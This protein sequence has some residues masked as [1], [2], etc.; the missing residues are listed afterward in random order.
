[1]RSALVGGVAALVAAACGNTNGGGFGDH[2]GADAAAG[3]D[4]GHV[5]GDDGGNFGEGGPTQ[6]GGLV[7]DPKTCAD[8]EKFRSY[9]GCDY[10]P[11]A[12]PNY[13]WSIFD[14][15]VVVA[16]TGQQAANVTVTGPNAVNKSTTVQPNELAKIYLP[17][18]AGLKGQ[19]F[20]NQTAFTD[21][22]FTTIK[23]QG[24]YH[25]VSTVPVTVYQFSALEY[26]AAGGPQGKNWSSCPGTQSGGLGQCFSYSNDASLLLPS[27]AMTPNY[28]LMSPAPIWTSTYVGVTAVQDGTHVAVTLSPKASTP[29]GGGIPAGQ[30]NDVLH[31]TLD[32]GDVAEIAS[33]PGGSDLGGSLVQA[34]KAIEVIA[35]SPCDYTPSGND[36]CCDHLEQS[37]LPAETLGQHYVVTVPTSPGGS[38]VGHLVRVYGNQNGTHLTYAPSKPAGCPDT[39]DAG[40]VADCG[41]QADKLI[42]KQDFEVTG[43]KEFAVL[44][45]MLGGS[46]V[47]PKGGDGDPSISAMVAVEQWRN[48]YVFLAPDDYDTS[49]ADI[50]A[51]QG[52]SI[53]ID[54]APVSA[55]FQPI[56]ATTGVYRVKLGPGNKGAHVLTSDHPV[57]L[58]VI[59]Y[60]QYTS[61]QYPGGLNLGL[62]A[63]PP[64]PPPK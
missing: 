62:I 44:S 39:L 38:P 31:F 29:A 63:P 9:V 22:P 17:W 3:D 19:D 50:A 23:K 8:A 57:G 26:K 56:G 52:A 37:V 32:A 41:V 34:D 13:V 61:Y 16:N 18:V 2:G 6:D 24:A 53:L 42:T 51:P 35:G 30:P 58:Q 59:G 11:S 47:D 27:T 28:R 12:L 55:P 33:N 4:A 40:Q 49:Y 20:N 54:G 14:F 48:K 21:T 60:G 1:M 5:G 36:C 64:P 15:A 45:R 43:D 10:W 7:G 25:L 46:I